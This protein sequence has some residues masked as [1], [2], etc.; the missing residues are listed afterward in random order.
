VS[1][2]TSETYRLFIENPALISCRAAVA[3]ATHL[4]YDPT[5]GR[6]RRGA[7]AKGNGGCRRLV[8]VLQQFDCTFDLPMLTKEGLLELLPQEF[9]RFV[10]RQMELIA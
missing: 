10:P 8:M 6:L 5:R 1:V 2:A 4:Y 9:E 7:G 3:V